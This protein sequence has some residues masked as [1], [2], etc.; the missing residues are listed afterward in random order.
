[1]ASRQFTTPLSARALL[2]TSKKEKQMHMRKS[3]SD[4]VQKLGGKITRAIE[5]LLKNELDYERSRSGTA[6]GR[7]S[8]PR[9]SPRKPSTNGRH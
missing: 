9:P 6:G 8:I 5:K 7:P 1:M 2:R 4:A 3:V